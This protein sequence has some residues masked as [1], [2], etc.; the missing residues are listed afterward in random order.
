M[1][2]TYSCCSFFLAWSPR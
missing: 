1:R 2:F